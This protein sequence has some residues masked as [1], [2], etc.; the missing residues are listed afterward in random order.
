M[1]DLIFFCF[2]RLISANSVSI[3][4]FFASL[5]KAHVL[6]MTVS[7]FSRETSCAPWALAWA[8]IVSESTVFRAQP[9]LIKA[10]RSWGEKDKELGVAAGD[11]N[12]LALV[13]DLETI[14]GDD[15]LFDGA[16]VFSAGRGGLTV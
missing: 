7:A 10:T 6:T 16:A 14:L 2:F 8:K 15:K 12:R 1:I 4:S 13:E 9:K 11:T 3:V 5:I